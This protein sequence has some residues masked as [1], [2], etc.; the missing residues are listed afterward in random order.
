MTLPVSL[1][2]MQQENDMLLMTKI[3]ENMVKEME[4]I[5]VLNLKQKLLNQIFVITQML[6]CL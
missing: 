4:I 6:M 1:Q 5:Q 2:N 3:M